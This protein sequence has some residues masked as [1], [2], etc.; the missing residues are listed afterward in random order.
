MKT[1]M[2]KMIKEIFQK[3]WFPFTIFT[4]LIVVL[5]SSSLFFDLTYSDDNVLIAEDQEYLQDIRNIPRTFTEDAF[6]KLNGGAYYRPIEKSTYILSTQFQSES[7]PLLCYHLTNII[8]HIVCTSLLFI[9][10][11]QLG[12]NRTFAFFTC[13]IFATHPLNVQSVA[14]ITGR[15]D[16]GLALFSLLSF[17]TLLKWEITNSKKW[18][19]G[20]IVSFIMALLSKE[21]AVFLPILHW[22]LL[23]IFRKNKP[24]YIPPAKS[25]ILSWMVIIPIWYFIRKWALA[26]KLE[27]F[28]GTS[29]ALFS[30]QHITSFFENLP[31]VIPHIGKAIFPFNLSPY[32]ILEDMTFFYGILGIF[33]TSSLT[34]IFRKKAQ[35]PLILFGIS[36]FF[37]ILTP[38]FINP[39]PEEVKVFLE[40]RMYLP[41]IGIIIII[42]ELIRS[43]NLSKKIW[44]P[45]LGLLIPIFAGSTYVYSQSYSSGIAYW[46][47]SI[48][49]TPHSAFSHN[50]LG[51]M[52]YLDGQKSKAESAWQQALK[53]NPNQRM[54]N[55]NIGLIHM[56]S[57][58]ME[59]A[60][61]F[62]LNELAIN[63]YYDQGHFNL[64]YLYFQTCRTDLAIHHWEQSLVFN[65]RYWDSY[66]YLLALY[67]KDGNKAKISEIIKRM[68]AIQK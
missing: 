38:T 35:L 19:L 7:Y 65:P 31:A 54:V 29:G 5:Y 23:W 4:F 3:S 34:W 22:L 64:G 42:A 66:N 27:I 36:M 58:Q 16:S 32:S 21:N 43:M 53:I 61:Q 28:T 9:F 24:L 49:Q 48:Q 6:R 2:L 30:V 62:F 47:K 56:N 18:F 17:V 14:W 20:Y 37:L 51:A 40:N 33:L 39:D 50:N 41:T 57:E 44:T 55:M 59:S 25:I 8:W 13:L 68:Q 26:S 67:K 1:N 46:E 60:E 11:G 15:V 10:L 63:P 12:W 45:L 52:Y